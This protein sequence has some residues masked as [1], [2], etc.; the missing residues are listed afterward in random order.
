MVYLNGEWIPRAEA[1]VAVDDRGFLFGDGVYEVTRAV[2]GALY[3]AEAHLERLRRGLAGLEF[4]DDAVCPESLLA[5]S[6]RL[7]E[8]NGLMD[9]QASVYL[10]VTRGSAPRTHHF[11]APGT[12]PTVYLSAS[13]FTPPA[14]LHERGAAAITHPDLR[15]ARCDLKTVNLLPNV[16]AKQ[17]AVAAGANE[18][19]LIRHGAV[20]EGS[21][22]NVFGVLNGELRTYP[23]CRQI[24]PGIT[25]DVVLRIAAELALPVSETP[26]RVDELPR[27]AELFITGTTTDV[28]PIVRLDGHPVGDGT[29]G[30]VT[31]RLQDAHREHMGA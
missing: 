20:T 18:A 6:A 21:H 9:G 27:L 8:V 31:R 13:R 14:E 29:P 15:W 7:L 4:A 16:L 2:G 17:H 22:S 1:R 25:R 5:V 11:P 19:I 10:Q 3:E 30:P 28:M 12:A 24:L 26:I 23:R